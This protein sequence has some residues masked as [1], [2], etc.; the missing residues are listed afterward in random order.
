[1]TWVRLQF[2]VLA[3]LISVSL[4]ARQNPS[5][6]GAIPQPDSPAALA[7]RRA[8][9]EDIRTILGNTV[10]PPDIGRSGPPF[11]RGFL[12]TFLRVPN[13]PRVS[14]LDQ[15]WEAWQA[16]TGELPPDFDAMPSIP[17]L[18]DPLML[19]ENGR[20]TP[21]TTPEQWARQ[22][23]LIRAGFEHWM[24]GTMPP[25]PTNLRGTVTATRQEGDVT[26]QDVLLEF[27][28]DRKATLHLQL[29]IPPGPGPFPVFLTNHPRRRPWAN[30]AVSRGYVACL[31]EALDQGYVG[32]DDS[33][34]WIDL[35]P[36]YAF[37]LLARWAW[38]AMRA[39]DYLVTLP[40]VERDHIA[41]AGHSKNSKQAL[42]AA[43]FDERIG[44]VVPSRGNSLDALPIR[45]NTYPYM[46]EP[47]E[48]VTED[49]SSYINPRLRFF[50]GRE[51]K[52][53][54]DMNLLQALVAPRGLLLSH[55]YTEHQGNT[56]A[57][58]QSYRSV[59]RVYQFLG[60]PDRV[61]LYQQPGEHPASAEDIDVYFDFFDSV[62]G[63]RH[64]PTP[65]DFVLGYTFERW[66]TQ[67]GERIDPLTFPARSTGDF[68]NA[69]GAP[70][71][72]AGWPAR[73]AAITD[74]IQWML[75]QAPPV[76]PYPPL[77]LLGD[78]TSQWTSEGFLGDMLPR[79]SQGLQAVPISFGNALKGEVYLPQG[80]T[81]RPPRGEK[82][83]LVIWLHGYSY[84]T[85]YSRWAFWT[86]LVNQG[87]AVMSF[88]QIGFGSR[89]D[90]Q[91][92]FYDR[93]P[94]WSLLGKMVADTR[95]AIDAVSALDAIDTSRIYIAG[96]GL[97]AK[98]GLVTAALD[99]RVSA[100]A[101]IA[102]IAPLRLD[103]PEN[104]T[105]GIRHYSHLHGLLPRFG[106]F[107]GHNDRL[108]IDFDEIL[109]AVA[110]RPVFVSAPTL[111]RYFPV[112]DVSAAV[113]ASN[114]VYSLLG[115][116]G[117]ITLDT[118]VEFSR[119]TNAV[120]RPAY[121]WLARLAGLATAPP[122]AGGK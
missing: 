88:D 58:E 33:T 12:S 60:Q 69:D 41:L 70:L 14:P 91:L 114:Q 36:E 42:L 46:S 48:A 4:S 83:P 93:Y 104:G 90:Q 30:V 10:N 54:V 72:P 78:T 74:N 29:L 112:D 55:A 122:Q 119:Y 108:P 115:R 71:T 80:K 103:T 65:E 26:V 113:A 8:A 62:F 79:P 13:G 18:P 37:S 25:A 106:F 17:E 57:V 47:L 107:V 92:H 15:N 2:I 59:Q 85:G 66:L 32:R 97:G 89:A 27:G 21:V 52:L 76:V 3:V 105:E 63:R 9:L 102:G 118:P 96:V 100:L 31:Y 84:S 64:T 24:Y 35:Y 39:V 77:R 7:R 109:A 45:Y 22:R 95:A 19:V 44:A 81:S 111:D 11:L 43:A 67:S 110:P 56:F 99:S 75:G 6:D 86:P 50:V 121:D 40:I 38:G 49:L 61:G 68:L 120:Q 73:V 34:A 87:F 23:Q 116:P 51:H 5:S 53:P 117:G 20:R 16:R 98:V 101:L 94:D 28:P 1:M 82:W